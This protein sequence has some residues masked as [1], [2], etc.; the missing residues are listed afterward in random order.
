MSSR[1][2][3]ILNTKTLSPVQLVSYVITIT[4]P[5]PPNQALDRLLFLSLV[6]PRAVA[7]WALAHPALASV[8]GDGAEAQTA[9]EALSL[10]CAHVVEGVRAARAALQRAGR[11]RAR[12]EKEEKRGGELLD[13]AQVGCSECYFV[14][15]LDLALLYTCLVNF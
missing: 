8:H 4:P 15:S 10:A 5:P 3:T 1:E 6:R 7:R 14:V 9:W 13:M 12:A 2:D 11:E